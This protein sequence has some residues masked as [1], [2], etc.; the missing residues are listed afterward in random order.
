MRGILNRITPQTFQDLVDEFLALEISEETVLR[1]VIDIFFD[2][3][4]EEPSYCA[5]YGQLCH[6]VRTVRYQL[7]CLHALAAIAFLVYLRMKCQKISKVISL[8]FF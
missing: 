1:G 2:K 3:A 6:K 8:N 7:V 4:V 5:L